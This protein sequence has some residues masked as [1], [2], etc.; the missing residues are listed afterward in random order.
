V[1]GFV[2]NNI[3]YPEER[4]AIVVLTNQMTSGAGD[5]ADRIANVL[6]PAADPTARNSEAKVRDAFRKLQKGEIDRT[7][8]TEN[9]N[10]YFNDVVLKDFANSL[11]P[12]GEPAEMNPGPRRM[13]GG[14]VVQSYRPVVGGRK[15]RISVFETPDGKFEQFKIEPI[16]E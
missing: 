5:I 16:A 11:G 15:I 3:V 14:F 10:D 13:R 6:F 2:A 8:F 9:A 7:L 4:A 12:L 1:M